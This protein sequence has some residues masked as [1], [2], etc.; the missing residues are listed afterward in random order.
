M[1]LNLAV[2]LEDSARKHPDKVVMILD[3]F[4]MTY[5]ELDAASNQVANA[6]VDAGL[7]QGDRVGMM[8]PNVPQFPVVYFGIL[9]AGMIAVPMNVLLKAPEVEYYLSDSESSAFVYFDMFAA[10]AIKGADAVKSIKHK[11]QVPLI[12]GTAAPEGS[13]DLSEFTKG[14]APTFDMVATEADDICLLIYTSGTTGHPKGAALTNFNLFM[15]CHNGTHIFEF[16]Q[17]TDVIMATLPMFHSFGLSNVVNGCIHG[18]ITMTLLP[19]FDA[20]KALEII[21]R[22]K[23]SLFLGVP[24]MYF[25][26]LNH[27]ERSTYDTSTLRLC[28]SGG[29]SIPGEVLKAWEDATGT[30]ILEG[31]GLSETSPTAT[32]NQLDVGTKVGSIGTAVFG[33]DVKIFDEEGKEVA[34]GELGEIVIKGHNIMK[35]YWRKPEATAESI[36]N[37]W[38]HSGDIGYVD[39]DGFFFIVDRKK[40]M[41]I[42]GG[43][44]VY[45]REIEEVIYAFPQVA[46]AAVIGI[47]DEK[48]GEEVV[49]V[50]APKPGEEIDVGELQAFVKERVA[51]YK[52][53]RKIEVVKEL[54]KGPTGKIMKREIKLSEAEEPAKA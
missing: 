30:K 21:Q 45:P 53:P 7:K 29:A 42:R 38:F 4:K 22:D 13:V 26:M 44:N 41:I 11:V 28:V 27:P 33:V 10:E 17:D 5:A 32:F 15:C 37:G 14:K 8:L 12:P 20:D 34:Q 52:Y 47:P 25:A 48:F 35:E 16:H 18:G 49:A 3:D 6:L 40:E 50:V 24:T 1:S 36:K 23:V 43:F 39:E 51:A 9:K 19:R 2:I 46:E 31:Y 54:P